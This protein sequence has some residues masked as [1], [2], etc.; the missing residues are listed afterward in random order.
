MRA[1]RFGLSQGDL[2]T[3]SGRRSLFQIMCSQRPE[4]VW[5]SP[6]CGPWSGF[7]TLN[8]SRSLEAW[9]ALQTD[10]L[11]HMYQLALGIVLLRFQRSHDRHLHWEQPRRSL[12]FKVPYLE[13][14][15]H[16]T[17]AVD[18]D[19]CAAG[20]LKDPMN[21]K[22]IKKSL[23]ILTTSQ[24]M[25]DLLQHMRCQGNHDHQVIEGHVQVN[26][27][28]MNR[29]AF[30]ERYP[31]KFARCLAQKMN[32]IV[33]PRERPYRPW[34]EELVL[35]NHDEPQDAKKRRV[36]RRKP[37]RVLDLAHVPWGKRQK[38]IGK[39]KPVDATQA[40]E[41]I[42]V[43]VNKVL[44]RVG[45][46]T[47][48]VDSH[49]QVFQQIQSLVPNMHIRAI[50]ACKGSNRTMPPPPDMFAS[51]APYRRSVFTER[52]T[53]VMK[54]EEEWELWENLA[55]RNVIRPFHP[56][57][58]NITMFARKPSTSQATTSPEN[59]ET[60]PDVPE[61]S[62]NLEPVEE[63]EPGNIEV[64][65]PCGDVPQDL[66]PPQ[67]ADLECP[68]QHKR[69]QQ[70][71]NEERTMIV[72]AHKNL[73]HPSPEKLSSLFRS[74]GYRAEVAQ[75]CLEYKCSICQA[76]SQ[77]KLAKPGSIRDDLDF[78]DRISMDGITWT[79]QAGT[80]FHAYHVVDWATSFQVAS[81]AP[82]RSSEAVSQHLT[83]MW[84]SWAGAPGE[85]LVDAATELN[86]EDIAHFMQRHNIKMTT[87]SPE[88]QFQNGKAE[89]HGDILKTMLSKYEVDHPITNYQEFQQ[90]LFW[91]IQAKNACSLRKG[92]APEVLVLGKHTRL[93][94]AVCSDEL[95]PAHML[96]DA[97][98][99][100]GVQF[101]KQLAYRESA[102][103]AFHA[104][105][106]DA[107]LRRALL[108]RSR[109]GQSQYSPGEWVMIWRQ[110]KGNLPGS[111]LGPQKVVVHENAQTIWTTSACKLYRSAPEHVRPVTAYEAKGIPMLPKEPSI[112]DIAN[113]IPRNNT[114]GITRNINPPDE[115]PTPPTNVVPVPNNP[116]HSDQNSEQPDVEPEA[117]SGP[118]TVHTPSVH[119]DSEQPVEVEAEPTVDAVEIPVPDS[120]GDELT[121]LG[122][123]CVEEGSI[124]LAE[125]QDL[126]W[127]C[128][129]DVCDKDIESWKAESDHTAM[130]FVASAA[131]RQRSEVKLSTLTNDEKKQFHKAKMAEVDNWIKTGTISRI[132]REKIPHDQ[133]LRCRWILT[134]KPIDP[135][136]EEPQKTTKAKARLVI[137]GYL[138]P[139]LEELPRDSPTLGRHAKMLA[140]QLI[141]SKMWTL[142]SFD[143]RAAF[144][145]GKAQKDRTLAVEPVPELVEALQL[146]QNEVCKL[147]KGAYGLVD[148]PYL[149]FV[150]LT[151]EL[152][153]LGF[154]QSPFDPC[155]FVVRHHISGR[156][157]GVL[158]VHVDDGICGGS[159]YFLDKIAALEKKYPFGSKKIQQFTFTG[160]D[161]NQ[162]PNGTITMNQSKYCR[163]I[164][165]IRIPNER[166]KNPEALV[167]EE[168]R[169]QLRALVG[170][171]QY[172]SVHTRPDISS[173]LSML[174][175][176][177]NRAK[178]ETL[179]SANQTLHETKKFHDV[180]I[181]IHPIKIEDFRFLAFSDASFASKSNPSSHTGCIIMGTHKD[182]QNN[183][184][185]LVSPL[186][187]SCKKIQRVVTSTLAAETVSLNSVLDQLS[188]MRLCWAWLLDNSIN[189]KNPTATLKTLP[190]TVATAT[191]QAQHLPDSIAATDC[192]SLYD[193]VTRT[194]MPN[195]AEFR[196]QLTARSIKDL[197]QEGVSL[198]WVHSGAQLADSLTKVME[199][200]FLRETLKLGRYR[201]H[202]ELSV[203][204]A[205]ASARN[206]LKW[207]Q[208]SQPK[209]SEDQCGN[210]CLLAEIL[211][212]LGVWN[213]SLQHIP[214]LMIHSMQWLHDFHL[215]FQTVNHLSTP[216]QGGPRRG[217]WVGN[218]A[219]IGNC[220][221]RGRS[222][223]TG[224]SPFFCW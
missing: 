50:V 118:P 207:L 16:Y 19:L 88:A 84:F 135:S 203:L 6:T 196:T 32:K 35:A 81:P 9:D 105:D 134:W 34:D 124:L 214:I 114:Q 78:N 3:S 153:K 53:N 122:Y 198:R 142:M 31:R 93:P 106:N 4:H 17:L 25:V 160:I 22:P 85:L 71:S 162:L 147:E 95:L 119:A 148:A 65:S 102:R 67:R 126:A 168:E 51:E 145:Q 169:Q 54:V 72:R 37:S 10:R 144:L 221:E 120:E 97:E 183:M 201:L 69:F 58:I 185:C 151:E 52:G 177:I 171:L 40:W 178:I 152:A 24:S 173:R 116:P 112:S 27:V 42:F 140:L 172:A 5:F 2:K 23:T 46:R 123:H 26:G 149:W 20:D 200:S 197:L 219:A 211:E 47:L 175:S 156:L 166:R 75:A 30:S 215:R 159:Q 164:Q 70:L 210:E 209:S 44:P 150:A 163:N 101:R 216:A 83:T 158:G 57:K 194:A 146:S 100:Q 82:N 127:R 117:P 110:G 174:Q 28:R 217:I 165:P 184:S 8:G 21:G 167:T 170:S 212:N 206:R 130:A 91:C 11:E 179:I 137:L 204:K 66:T 128:E 60:V 190:E 13:E 129:I 90:G 131:K 208:G 33:I 104:A 7:S 1:K 38:C 115:S 193:L 157:E 45:K 94:G 121:C 154:I 222:W 180:T 182:I 192:K 143:I 176:D 29:S 155:L 141:A 202:D 18:V 79:S 64:P 86:S 15:R 223:K 199:T 48:T 87:I 49:P 107:A 213:D 132:L 99:A 188:W 205:R 56:S 195:C 92:Y 68:S 113:Q 63:Q 108:R 187:W 62:T 61:T 224:S 89:R 186:S 96:A 76:S 133:I 181:Q 59:T 138:D 136:P 73:G 139:K 39:T 43:E 218:R 191:Y 80:N 103:K 220:I 161:M 125:D 189:W 98:T 109:P 14:V 12:M 36:D 74:Q 41:H 77:P 55:K 111:W